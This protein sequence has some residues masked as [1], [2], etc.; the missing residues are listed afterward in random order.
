MFET[1]TQITRRLKRHGNIIAITTIL[2]SLVITVTTLFIITQ[3]QRPTKAVNQPNAV[4]GIQNDLIKEENYWED[5]L[6]KNPEYI[7]G[8]IRL[9]QIEKELGNLVK[10]EKY[11]NLAIEI[12]PNSEVLK[13]L[14]SNFIAQ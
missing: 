2:S 7:V 8:Y 6:S 12:D 1:A 10:F 11:Y 3:K 4:L 14:K 9:I 5:F 13:S